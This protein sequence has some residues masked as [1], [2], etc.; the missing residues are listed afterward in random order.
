MTEMI[1]RALLAGLAAAPLAPEPEPVFFMPQTQVAEEGWTHAF[2]KQV[3]F[4]RDAERDGYV[5]KR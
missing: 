4:C 1:R 3:G 5:V 2:L